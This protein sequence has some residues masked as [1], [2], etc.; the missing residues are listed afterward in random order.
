VQNTAEKGNNK[1]EKY[2][3]RSL[4]R[5]HPDRFMYY[6]PIS[7]ICPKPERYYPHRRKEKE[8][9]ARI[10]KCYIDDDNNEKTPIPL[11]QWP[12]PLFLYGKMCLGR[13]IA[14][15]PSHF[16]VVQESRPGSFFYS[17]QDGYYRARA[18]IR[19]RDEEKRINRLWRDRKMC[20][21]RS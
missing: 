8:N 18:T 17:H 16:L 14:L 2:F 15:V 1:K 19:R 7:L 13:G 12:F 6:D 21:C 5:S 3:A 10:R 20:S 9:Q 4:E 11:F